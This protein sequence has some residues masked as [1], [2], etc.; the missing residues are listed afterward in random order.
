M[1]IYIHIPYCDSKC[2]YCAFN[3]Y[4]NLH[5]TIPSYMKSLTKVITKALQKNKQ[6]I[7]TIFIGGG[8]PSVIKPQYYEEI[9]A[10]LKPFIN[11]ESEISIEANPNSAT[12]PWLRAMRSLGVNRISF[13]VQSFSDE[14]LRYLNRAHKAKD[15]IKAIE[16][17]YKV[18]FNNISLD[19]LYDLA[20]DS[21]ELL[22]QDLRLAFSLPITHIST[23]ELTLEEGSRF[24]SM[25]KVKAQK[26]ELNFFIKETIKSYGLKQYEVSNYGKICKHNLAYWEHKEY[27]GFGAGVVGFRKNYRYYSHKNIQ[28]FINDPFFCEKEVLSKEDILLEKLFLGLRSIVGVEQK[29]LPLNMQERANLLVKEKKLSFTNGKYFNEDYF[30]ADELALFIMQN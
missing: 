20:I 12:L 13:G 8:T 28:N 7:A 30:L 9:F 4:T 11:N 18:G 2:F 25:P 10:F 1:H 29:I 21:K 22:E 16:N 23:Y 5:F 6:K 24:F 26:E 14:K 3:S 19:L 27:L 15:A 17:A